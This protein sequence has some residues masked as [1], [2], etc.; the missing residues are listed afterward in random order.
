MGNTGEFFSM[1]R[2]KH[3]LSV[4]TNLE[5]LRSWHVADPHWHLF[6]VHGP[7]PFVFTEIGV[8][9]SLATPLVK[10]D[11]EPFAISTC[12]SIELK[13][14]SRRYKLVYSEFLNESK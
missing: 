4:V 2:S 7:G 12:K 11:V 5:N 3:E 14:L 10:D 6:K 8:L 13:K 9:A 1:T